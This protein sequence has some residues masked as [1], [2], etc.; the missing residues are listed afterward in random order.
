MSEIVVVIV[1]QV[2]DGRPGIWESSSA[3]VV[4]EFTE[5]LVSTFR[6]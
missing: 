2:Q 4:Q 1:V 5:I 6:K 3:F